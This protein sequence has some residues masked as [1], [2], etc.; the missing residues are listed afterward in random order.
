[1]C[2]VNGYATVETVMW[3]NVRGRSVQRV[4]SLRRTQKLQVR[5]GEWR[6]NGVYARVCKCVFRPVPLPQQWQTGALSQTHIKWC[7]GVC[8]FLVDYCY[9]FISCLD[10]HSDGT[11]S[12]QSIHWW[13]SDGMLN[14]SKSVLMKKRTHHG[15]LEDDKMSTNVS[16]LSELFL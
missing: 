5:E 4:H 14:F 1:M 9:V 13:A 2:E 3:R 12:L 6:V 16:F 10:S 15:W 8:G 7:P 11:H